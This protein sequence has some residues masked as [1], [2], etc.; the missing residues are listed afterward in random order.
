LVGRR[1]PG[2]RNET[3][4]ACHLLKAVEGWTDLGL[5]KFELFYLRDKQKREVDFLVAR[6]GSPWFLAEAKSSDDRL[7]PA[8]AHFQQRTGAAHAFQV[9][10]D[11]PYVAADCFARTTPVSVPALT[12]LSQLL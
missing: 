12:F 7:S 4:L 1:R 8:L 2:Q 9:V 3:L 5:G 6:D 10:F 11:A